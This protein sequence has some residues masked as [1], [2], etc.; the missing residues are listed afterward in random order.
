ML[1]MYALVFLLVSLYLIVFCVWP[2]AREDYSCC[3]KSYMNAKTVVA[4][5]VSAKTIRT[6]EVLG[7]DKQVRNAWKVI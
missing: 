3:D 4:E 6:V 7:D 2:V 5:N 1:Y